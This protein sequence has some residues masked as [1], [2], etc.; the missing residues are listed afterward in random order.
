MR[1]F[2]LLLIFPLSLLHSQVYFLTNTAV[3]TKELNYQ[4]F[5]NATIHLYPTTIIKDAILLQQNGRII[6]IGQNIKSPSNTRV[7]DKTGLIISIPLNEI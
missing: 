6:A 3:K 4:A 5:T 7:Y 1:K 2:L